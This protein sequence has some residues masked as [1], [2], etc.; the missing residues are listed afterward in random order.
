[1]R[2]KRQRGGVPIVLRLTQL[3][4]IDALALVEAMTERH[5]HDV[6]ARHGNGGRRLPDAASATVGHRTPLIEATQETS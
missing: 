2:P 5:E 3:P 6:L 1:M 4:P